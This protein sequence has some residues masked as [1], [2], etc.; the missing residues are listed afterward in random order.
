MAKRGRPPKVVGDF[1]V[2]AEEA[3]VDDAVDDAVEETVVEKPKK[4]IPP[5]PQ[6]TPRPL[7]VG[8]FNDL[9]QEVAWLKVRVEA[10][11]DDS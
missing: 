3:K 7:G 2:K 1:E 11:E 6:V 9:V 4:E 10:L 8:S 5:R